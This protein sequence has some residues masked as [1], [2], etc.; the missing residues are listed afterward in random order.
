MNFLK[1]LVFH[2]Y[3]YSPKNW[4]HKQH[5]VFKNFIIFIQLITLP[6][7]PFWHLLLYTILYLFVYE[8]IGLSP[9][10]KIHAYKMFFILSSFTI[11]G[12]QSQ[13]QILKKENCGRNYIL[14]YH[15]ISN[16][17]KNILSDF[18]L[19]YGFSISSIRLSQIYL[20]YLIMMKLLVLTTKQKDILY[21]FFMFFKNNISYYIPK[22]IFEIQ[23]SLNFLNII[24]K[25]IEI[26]QIRYST[27]SLIVKPLSYNKEN[28]TIFLLNMQQLIR[29]IYNYIY[30]VSNTLYH[31]EIQLNNLNVKY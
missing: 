25:Q 26:M 19:L 8:N 10:F 18:Y 6:Y 24:P 30:N 15:Q 12:I 14:I 13:Q 29:T 4:L 20:L 31:N 16:R 5:N 9:K 17:R 28:L 11:L 7:L 21:C 23:I 1:L 22:F 2:E 3:L 27:R